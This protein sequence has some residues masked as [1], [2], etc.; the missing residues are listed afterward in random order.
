MKKARLVTGL[1]VAILAAAAMAEA[2]GKPAGLP[3]ASPPDGLPGL[4]CSIL[5]DGVAQWI[6][7]CAD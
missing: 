2:A 7:F 5:P 4:I 6:P 1:F 3:P